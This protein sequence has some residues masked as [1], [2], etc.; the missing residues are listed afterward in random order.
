MS[1]RNIIEH[2]ERTIVENKIGLY[3]ISC[4]YVSDEAGTWSGRLDSAPIHINI[5]KTATILDNP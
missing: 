1:D 5:N 3:Q 4:S 2:F